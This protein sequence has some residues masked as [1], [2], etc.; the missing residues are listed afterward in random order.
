M[1]Q[2]AKMTGRRK[3]LKENFPRQARPPV[4][5]EPPP[6]HAIVQGEEPPCMERNG[7]G[8]IQQLLVTARGKA[9]EELPPAV[10]ADR[11]V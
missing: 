8:T 3:P 7:S 4:A 1:I 9:F 10:A 11:N 2:N 5:I 6:R